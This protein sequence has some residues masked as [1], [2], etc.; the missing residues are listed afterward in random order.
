MGF[1]MTLWRMGKG[2]FEVIGNGAG[3][4]EITTLASLFLL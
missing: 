1:L 4:M 3:K 2:V